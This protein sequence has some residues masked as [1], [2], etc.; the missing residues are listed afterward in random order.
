MHNDQQLPEPLCSPTER[1]SSQRYPLGLIAQTAST[2]YRALDVSEGG[3]CLETAG[4]I[5]KIGQT[6]SVTFDLP[7][8]AALELCGEVR[9]HRTTG[10]GKFG[11]EFGKKLSR[12]AL[13][14]LIAASTL[15][16]P[17]LA[18][19]SASKVPTFD[20]H[21]TINLDHYNGSER[22]DERQVMAAFE[23]RN[24]RID[25]CV[26]KARGA[27]RKLDGDAEISILLNPAG[28]SPKG[29]NARVPRGMSKGKTLKQCLRQAVASADYPSY[30]GP[31]IV[32]EFEFEID[33]GFYDEQG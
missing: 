32:V 9:W 25:A 28:H 16:A 13:A 27:K 3:L 20:P 2:A 11:L 14:A 6:I 22:P 30:N 17:S 18:E 19:A 8:G 12:G 33:P 7:T 26:A 21:A 24:G 1:R 5:P 29:V 23:T 31:P 15:V 4:I 10:A